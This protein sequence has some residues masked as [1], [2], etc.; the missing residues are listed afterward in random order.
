VCKKG[1]ARLA[2]RTPCPGQEKID[3]LTNN[4]NRALTQAASL[5]QLLLQHDGGRPHV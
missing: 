3:D 2:L 4:R 5:Q 1:S